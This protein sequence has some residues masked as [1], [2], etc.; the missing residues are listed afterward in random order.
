MA[1]IYTNETLQKALLIYL[2]WQHKTRDGED[3]IEM[4]ALQDAFL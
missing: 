3:C 2:M 4:A 1:A